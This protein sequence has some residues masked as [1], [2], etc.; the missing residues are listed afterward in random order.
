MV[1]LLTL[2]IQ[3]AHLILFVRR[4]TLMFVLFIA[5][6]VCLHCLLTNCQCAFSKLKD[7]S[8]L[9]HTKQTVDVVNFHSI[10]INPQHSPGFETPSHMRSQPVCRRA[11]WYTLLCYSYRLMLF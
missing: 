11:N 3:A 9:R 5:V 4:H 6:F 7:V 10:F 2:L 1:F 8:L